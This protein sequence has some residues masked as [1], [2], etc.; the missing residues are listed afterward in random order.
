MGRID[1]V[2]NSVQQGLEWRFAF[3]KPDNIDEMNGLLDAWLHKRNAV[4]VH[5][6]AKRTRQQMILDAEAGVVRRLPD[7]TEF[8]DAVV[9]R[10]ETRNIDG[11]GCFQFNGKLWRVDD[12]TVIN[13]KQ[14]ISVNPFAPDRLLVLK[15]FSL[16]SLHCDARI[17]AVLDPVNEFGQPASAI[18]LIGD[19]PVSAK[20]QP[21]AGDIAAAR[22]AARQIVPDIDPY[23]DL[24]E[25]PIAASGKRLSDARMAKALADAKPVGTDH[26]ERTYSPTAA[27]Y[28]VIDAL[29]RRGLDLDDADA[30]LLA[31]WHERPEVK[32]SEIEAFVARAVAVPEDSA[33]EEAV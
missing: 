10:P 26:A 4:S 21:F 19:H 23:A 22:R 25:Q 33:V 32:S 14:Y 28:R 8:L 13:S 2:H 6:A 9:K 18:P 17:E 1:S 27:I 16:D 7:S 11:R 12:P 15:N 3:A 5:R 20:K 31:E 30:A 29:K 24:R